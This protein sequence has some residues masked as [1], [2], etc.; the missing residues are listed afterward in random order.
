VG[1]GPGVQKKVEI[2]R[3]AALVPHFSIDNFSDLSAVVKES[4]HPQHI[5]V[6]V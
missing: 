1:V 5:T 4:K 3:V 6:S 2:L